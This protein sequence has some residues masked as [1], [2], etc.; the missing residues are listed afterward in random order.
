MA[1]CIAQRDLAEAPVRA[2]DEFALQVGS[3]AGHAVV[4]VAI[5][6][7]RGRGRLAAVAVHAGVVQGHVDIAPLR[8]HANRLQRQAVV[9][10]QI[11]T[12]GAD[13]TEVGQSREHTLGLGAVEGAV[14]RAAEDQRAEAVELQCGIAGGRVAAVQHIG[15]GGRA[16]R[17]GEVD[18]VP[19]DR[20][21][22]A[23]HGSRGPHDAEGLGVGRLGT[24]GRV[25][26]AEVVDLSG[27]R[28]HQHADLVVGHARQLAQIG[29]RAG[30]AGIGCIDPVALAG[31]NR[32]VGQ[33]R[34][35]RGVQLVD[36]RSTRGLLGHGPDPNTR[37]RRPLAAELAGAVAL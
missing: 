13:D 12:G 16:D 28:G 24:Q 29:Q 18:V 5:P 21:R 19:V 34:D 20:Q 33:A 27:G 22:Q 31:V 36:R 9:R 7:N 32:Q 1:P 30:L 23:R 15:G 2:L 11:P 26:T 37:H 6:V 8:I 3:A 17:L 14:E 25:A 4:A 35:L 10:R